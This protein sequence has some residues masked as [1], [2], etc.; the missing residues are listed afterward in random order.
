MCQLT[1][2]EC[3]KL[4]SLELADIFRDYGQSYINNHNL[5]SQQYKAIRSIVACRTASL[6]G[7]VSRCDRC[8]YEL[9]SY[10][11]CRNRHCPKCQAMQKERW[12]SARKAEL[13][14]VEYFHVVF[15]LPH[16]LNPLAQ[17]KPKIIYDL[18]FQTASETLLQFSLNS[19]WL[20]AKPSITMVLHTWSQNI[21]HHI[22]V[23]CIVSG[24]GL[25]KNDQ[26]NNAKKKFLFPVHALSKVFRGKYL[27][28][29]NQALNN[30]EVHLP[31][32]IT[33]KENTQKFISLLYRSDW[34]VYAKPPFAGPEQVLEYLG[35]YT[36]R[37]AIGNQRLVNYQDN[38]VSFKWRDYADNSKQKIMVLNVDEFIRRY[39]LH[40]LPK[41]FQRLRHYGLLANRYKSI[42]LK[43]AR[44]AL[45]QDEFEPML[46]ENI[47]ELM[48][49]LTGVDISKCPR[50]GVGRLN[51]VLSLLPISGWITHSG[52]PPAEYI[53]QK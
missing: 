39:L 48:L 9:I 11:S 22:H 4:P 20:G 1:E 27:E 36:H 18:L 45:K 33:N 29:L 19:K 51:V 50:C 35:R 43:Q 5:S 25:T 52:D 17:G 47:N 21:D 16:T 28:R 15:T 26:W 37:I 6:G 12:I 2:H 38:M 44:I 46:K 14:P 7:H 10:N 8:E 31:N 34:V 40:V 3:I 42:N 13:L 30:E 41:G 32:D 53:G 23:H 24:G 49:R